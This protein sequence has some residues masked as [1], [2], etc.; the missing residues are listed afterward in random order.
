MW[1]G[2]DVILTGVFKYETRLLYFGTGILH[3]QLV[4]SS[5]IFKGQFKESHKPGNLIG[6]T[7]LLMH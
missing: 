5:P 3:K 4:F 6:D 7:A 1:N 2:Q